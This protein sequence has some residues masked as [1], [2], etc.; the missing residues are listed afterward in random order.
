VVGDPKSAFSRETHFGLLER[1]NLNMSIISS[2]NLFAKRILFWVCCW[3][4]YL[5]DIEL[6]D[7]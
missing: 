7:L 6:F 2:G 5:M 3:R 4:R 1:H